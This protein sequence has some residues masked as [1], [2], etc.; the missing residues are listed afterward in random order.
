MRDTLCQDQAEVVSAFQGLPLL[1]GGNFNVT[2]EMGDRPNRAGGRNPGSE[3]FGLFPS[4][5]ALQETGTADCV[6]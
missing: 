6:H 2:L 5:A 1:F 3:G 4:G